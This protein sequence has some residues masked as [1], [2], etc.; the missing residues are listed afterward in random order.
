MNLEYKLKIENAEGKPKD[1]VNKLTSKTDTQ[2]NLSSTFNSY[3][4]NYEKAL[5]FKDIIFDAEYMYKKHGVIVKFASLDPGVLGMTYIATN[6]V[7]LD[8]NLQSHELEYVAAHE[9]RH[10]HKPYKS[11]YEIR[12]MDA[13][14]IRVQRYNF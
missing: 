11:E 9:I 3:S 7:Y 12:K 13:Y 10:H 8:H 4:V 5:T 2:A 14:E 1:E 6:E